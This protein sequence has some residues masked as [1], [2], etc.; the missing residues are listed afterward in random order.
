M[1]NREFRQI[2]A[3]ALQTWGEEAQC[4]MLV[5]EMA[6]LMSAISK[7]KRD[8]ISKSAVVTEIADV[9]IMLHQMAI[10]FGIKEFIAEK[11]RKIKRLKSRL[12]STS[13][14]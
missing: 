14:N 10:L 6:E 11:N 2:C 3:E 7:Y 13:S 9:Y 4:L 12:E 1:E 5:E 8:R